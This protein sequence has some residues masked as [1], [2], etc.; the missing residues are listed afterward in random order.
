MNTLIWIILATLVSGVLSVLAAGTFLADPAQWLGEAVRVVLALDIAGDLGADHTL[1][2]GLRR[3]PLD[4][5]DMAPADALDRE[6]AGARAVVRADSGDA[7]ERQGSAPAWPRG[8][9]DGLAG[10]RRRAIVRLQRGPTIF[11]F[12]IIAQR[13]ICSEVNSVVNLQ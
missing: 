3:C 9:R 6:R 1:R 8:Y 2:V 12:I 7:V 10:S 4:P 11:G 13:Q 5:P